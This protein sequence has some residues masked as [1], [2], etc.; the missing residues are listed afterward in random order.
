[1]HDIKPL[2]KEWLKY[3]TKKR[4][5]WY[6]LLML[7]IPLFLLMFFFINKSNIQLNAFSKYFNSAINI[8]KGTLSLSNENV[9]QLVLVNPAL[10]SLELIDM[11][12]LTKTISSV[13]NESTSMSSSDLLVDIP[14]LDNESGSITTTTSN[15]EGNREKKYLDI[16]ET[17]SLSAYE[18]VEKRFH[19]SQDID[20]ALFLAKSYYKKGNYKKAAQWAYETNKLDSGLEESFLIFVKSKMKLG[21]KNEVLSILNQYLKHNNSKDARVLLNQIEN[22]QFD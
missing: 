7:G 9:H 13:N 20:D 3:Q 1:M 12:S 16:V 4:K 2:E 21:Q 18:D 22:H 11:H 5:P 8:K 19:R 14:I 6:F 15:N 10:K 17:T